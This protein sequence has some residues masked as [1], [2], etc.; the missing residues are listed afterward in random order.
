GRAVIPDSSDIDLRRKPE[1]E[2]LGHNVGGLKIEHV[3]RKCG[4]QCGA[5]LADIFCCR[6]VAILER[7]QDGAVIH[8]DRRSVG[9]SEVVCARRQSDIVNDQRAFIPWDDLANLIFDLLKN[10][11]GD[12]NPGT[13]GRTD[14]QLDL[15]AID[16]RKKISTDELQ[17]S[18]AEPEYQ[19]GR[20]R[21]D[22]AV[23]QQIGEECD[24]ALTHAIEAPVEPYLKLSQ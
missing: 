4:C 2:N 11:F 24:V 9:E 8:A 21:N 7:D 15:A 22:D 10:L 13:G 16:E 17:H 19:N 5:Q 3:L 1:V 20:G 23:L 18:G 12:F 6:R 14:M